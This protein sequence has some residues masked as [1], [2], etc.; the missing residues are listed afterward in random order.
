MRRARPFLLIPALAF[1]LAA[2]ACSGPHRITDP[3][4]GKVYYTDDLRRENIRGPLYKNRGPIHFTDA[5][6]KSEVTL[7]EYDIKS[8]SKHDFESATQGE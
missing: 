1:I 6:T 2:S 4:T 5:R 7:R 8:I 3:V